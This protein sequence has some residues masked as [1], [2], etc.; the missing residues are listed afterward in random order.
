MQSPAPYGVGMHIVITGAKGM[1]GR[2]LADCAQ[3]AGHAVT[4]HDLPE[5]DITR[6]LEGGNQ[7]AAG[8][9][10]VNCA[11]WT[12]VDGA[13]SREADVM[14]VNRDGAG[15]LA[16]WCAHHGTGMV[17][18]STDYVFDG[19]R[20]RPYGEDD[21]AQPL[22]VYGHSKLEGEQAVLS[23]HPRAW[24]VRTQSLFGL[25]GK[26]FV[27]A[28][29][30]AVEQGRVPL[31]VVN[32]QISCPTYAAH[33]ADALVCLVTRCRGGGRMHLAA[34]GSCS[35]YAFACAIV[36]HVYPGTQVLPVLSSEFPRPARR[37]ACS[38][39]DTSRF[40]LQTGRQLPPWT[41][42]LQEYLEAAGKITHRSPVPADAGIQA[43]EPR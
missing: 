11:A 17:Q 7:P 6:P 28:I 8:D 16:A 23:A 25:H 31:R 9:V 35:W 1:L 40:R 3:R 2:A 32:D 10:L 42:G 41:T 36:E 20:G 34:A 27:G 15:R 19:T 21:P 37:P 12:D 13:E 43:R 24:V 14:A 4:G 33:L 29:L 5:L 22:N 30:N 39:L 18:I 38:V 26:H